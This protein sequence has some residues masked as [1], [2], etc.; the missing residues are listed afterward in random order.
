MAVTVMFGEIGGDA[1]LRGSDASADY[2]GADGEEAGL[3]L[4]DDSQVIAM[5]G[6]R[7]L[8]WSGGIEFVA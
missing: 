6:G 4:G 1:N 7:E 3:F 5:D 2:R 8:F